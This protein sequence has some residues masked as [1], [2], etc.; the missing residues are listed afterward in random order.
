MMIGVM[1][2]CLI[3]QKCMGFC[4]FLVLISTV[5]AHDVW[6]APQ[7]SQVEP[8]VNIYNNN[9]AITIGVYGDNPYRQ[10]YRTDYCGKSYYY[11]KDMWGNYIYADP[12]GNETYC[13]AMQPESWNPEYPHFGSNRQFIPCA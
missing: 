13:P 12:E 1:M 7:K 11:S 8:F 2:T 5:S 3:G 9:A 10:Y 4:L 6:F